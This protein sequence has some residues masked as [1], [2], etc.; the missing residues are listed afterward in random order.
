MRIAIAQTAL[1]LTACM[2][3]DRLECDFLPDAT[4][5]AMT[6][7]ELHSAS[8]TVPKSFPEGPGEVHS[9]TS[10]WN[11]PVACWRTDGGLS[12]DFTAQLVFMSLWNGD[13]Y[14]E[15]AQYA[16]WQAED[17][18]AGGQRSPGGHLRGR[19]ATA[20]SHPSRLQRRHR[21]HLV[22]LATVT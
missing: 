21:H 7:V 3:D 6:V 19:S 10:G 20:R 22:W 12:P 14:E 13:G 18:P 1:V 5:V 16:A 2:P 11:E 9:I 4:E 15:S 8:F 17:K